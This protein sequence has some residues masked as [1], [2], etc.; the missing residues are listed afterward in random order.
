M[1]TQADQQTQT[2]ETHEFQAEVSRV[3][4]LMVRS[5]YSESE[6]FLRELVSNAADASDRLRYAALTD[7]A[8]VD[9]D[10]DYTITITADPAAG[11]LSIAD[12]GIGMS[13]DDLISN[14][15]T[16]ARSGTAAFAEQ[17]TGDAAKDVSLIGQFGVGFYAAFI[18]S[19]DVQVVSRKAGSDDAWSWRSDGQSDFKIDSAERDVRG[20]TV[21]LHVRDED[22]EYLEPARLRHIITT[23][24]DHIGL[25]IQ[26]AVISEDDAESVEAETINAASALWT[27]P[28]SEI[29]DEQYTEFYH[30]VAH[31]ADTPDQVLH[32]KAEGM[33]EYSA[34]LFI[35]GAQ[36]FDLF[37]PNR[38]P[39]VK[40]YVKRV[41]IT[42]DTGELI[43]GYLRFIRG[44]VDSEDLPLN[45]SREMLQNSPVVSRISKAV[46]GRVLSE[47]E[48]T[49]DKEPEQFARIWENFGPVLKEGIYEDE[50]RREAL[51]KLARFRTAKQDGWVSLAEYVAAMKED[52]KA[53]YY[54]SATDLDAARRSPHLEGF[55]SRGV[56]VLLFSDAVDDFW[57]QM[58]F[59]YEGVELKS[60]TRGGSDLADL[61]EAETKEDAPEPVADADLDLL[62][63]ALKENLGEHIKDVRTTDRLTDSPVCLVV[64]DT[65]M[66]INLQRILQQQNQLQAALPRILEINPRH[67]VIGALAVQA[68]G[69]GGMDA[70]A[71]AAYL[72]LDQAHILEGEGPLDPTEFSSRLSRLIAKS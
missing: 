2:T 58:V 53:I 14:L 9:G 47:L 16:V 46:T 27:R 6:I 32:Y 20:T 61:G 68:A 25:P 33:I 57:L 17:M 50:E 1:T 30:H 39:R 12:R 55:L 11:T 3:L 22:K 38:K 37:D 4:H 29:E 54:V 65:D 13:R 62:I 49:A 8:L 64:D 69:S 71:D 52:Q 10:G 26:L 51:L 66:D 7:T 36:P 24:S 5:V 60:I 21:T 28:K 45:I 31:A 34:L 63:A 70:V 43:P 15:G 44:V 23:Y 72:L 56:D 41:F 59:E 42:D 19:D 18:V 67:A 48:K 35:P 40:L